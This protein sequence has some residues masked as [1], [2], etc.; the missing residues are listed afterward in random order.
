MNM[1][2]IVAVSSVFWK[3]LPTVL[4]EAFARVTHAV[5]IIDK[6]SYPRKLPK[7]KPNA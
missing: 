2:A 6:L 7:T 1:S 4:S 5:A 3:T